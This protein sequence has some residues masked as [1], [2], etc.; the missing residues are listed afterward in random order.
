ML[1]GAVSGPASFASKIRFRA[2]PK[3][4][5]RPGPASV[6][7]NPSLAC[8]M[9]LYANPTPRLQQPRRRDRFFDPLLDGPL[10][11]VRPQAGEGT[12]LP[13]L[14]PRKL[15]PGR[16]GG[17][18]RRGRPPPAERS[19]FP[20]EAGGRFASPSRRD[21]RWEAR[22]RSRS[23][24][25]RSASREGYFAMT[26]PPWGGSPATPPEEGEELR[27]TLHR[28]H[29]RAGQLLREPP[30]VEEARGT[31]HPDDLA[32]VGHLADVAGGAGQPDH[33]H[34]ESRV[35]RGGR[36]QPDRQS[37]GASR[38][39]QQAEAVRRFE[40]RLARGDALQRLQPVQREQLAAHGQVIELLPFRLAQPAVGVERA[41]LGRR[42][43]GHRLAAAAREQ[44]GSADDEGDESHGLEV[45]Q[46]AAGG[47]HPHVPHEQHARDGVDAAADCDTGRTRK[48][49]CSGT[50]PA[51]PRFGPTRTPSPSR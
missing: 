47:G 36:R 51:P 7:A 40:E 44:Q 21:S 28:R 1:H 8:C 37:V 4:S 20:S 31:V 16:R 17:S 50:T 3:S 5:V 15:S 9:I 25:R 33:L 10:P 41:G 43:G 23:P 48:P 30:G 32:A 27:G 19:F 45:L 13:R 38:V 11:L 6:A 18:R 24:A 2:W 39:G 35:A 22:S 29:D 49:R 12:A 14:G 26:H 46:D 42:I 34:G